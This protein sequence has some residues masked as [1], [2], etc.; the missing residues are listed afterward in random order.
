MD[1]KVMHSFYSFATNDAIKISI[2]NGV[3]VRQTSA[4]PC[5]GAK[6]MFGQENE[7]S[8]AKELFKKQEKD[9]INNLKPKLIKALEVMNTEDFIN[10]VNGLKDL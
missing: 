8:K 1:F 6:D 5:P 2:D 10:Q 3:G 7:H 9:V 4:V